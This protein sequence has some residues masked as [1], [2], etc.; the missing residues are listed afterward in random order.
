MKFVLPDL[1]SARTSQILAGMQIPLWM[2][3]LILDLRLE[4]KIQTI[5]GLERDWEAPQIPNST[6]PPEF[7]H[8]DIFWVDS[9]LGELL[10]HICLSVSILEN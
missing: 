2:H 10:Q 5:S 9:W 6:I 7:I 8:P 1:S 3:S 4:G